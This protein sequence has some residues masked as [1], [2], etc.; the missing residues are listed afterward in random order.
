[1]I[2]CNSANGTRLDKKRVRSDE[3]QRLKNGARLELAGT[4]TLRFGLE[5]RKVK[6]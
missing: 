3:P 1:M 6:S 5:R 2:D 4:T